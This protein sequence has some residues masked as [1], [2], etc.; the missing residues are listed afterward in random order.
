MAYHSNATVYVRLAFRLTSLTFFSEFKRQSSDSCCTMTLNN[1]H[2]ASGTC[3]FPS[4]FKRNKKLCEVYSPARQTH[5]CLSTQCRPSTQ[6]AISQR[7]GVCR[8]PRCV[9]PRTRQP[10]IMMGNPCAASMYTVR[11]V[12]TTSSLF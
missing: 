1:T 3:A 7:R 11:I 10:L 2:I 5:F 6:L 4:S 9:P 8:P 12:Y